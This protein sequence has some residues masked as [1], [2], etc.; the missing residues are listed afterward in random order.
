MTKRSAI[1]I[2]GMLVAALM[3]G[4]AGAAHQALT[5]KAAGPPK[6]VVVV[7]QAAQPAQAPYE[8]SD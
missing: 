7:Q 3:A 5:L 6:A 8:D 4:V 2:S 1:V